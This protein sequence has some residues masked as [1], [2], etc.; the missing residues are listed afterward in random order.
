MRVD[1]TRVVNLLCLIL[2][3]EMIFSLPFHITRYFR[4]SF[5]E[6]FSLSN[7]ALGDIFALYGII[8]MLSYFPGG[9]LADKF[10]V[11]R[12]LTFSLLATAAGGLYLATIPGVNGL[13][14]LFAYWGMT[15][16]LLFWAALLRATREWG[17][18][19]RQGMAFGLLDG[20]R[21]LTAAIAAT[22]AVA[23]FSF[24][25]EG[26]TEVLSAVERR[27]GMQ[28]VFYFYSAVTGLVALL[29]W[30]F[31]RERRES[32]SL[33]APVVQRIHGVASNASVWLQAAIV[34]TAYC[35][36]KG[37][38]NY[39][40]YLVDV[41]Q[42]DEVRAAELMA[43][44]AYLRPVGAI[45][46]GLIADRFRPSRVIVCLFA[47]LVIIY[48]LLA[49]LQ[50]AGI[51]YDILMFNL[52]V[53]FLA[54]FALRGVYFA[55]LEEGRVASEQTGTAIGLVSVIGFTPDIFFY[56][57]GGRLLDRNPG[58]VGHQHYFWMLAAIACI[59]LFASLLLMRVVK[60]EK[61]TV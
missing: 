21:G 27:A 44:S 52:W 51:R 49:N 18:A 11:R 45:A 24:F 22:A 32:Q 6:T 4:P 43:M 2:A 58:I 30:M 33:P 31:V 20:G 9:L 59:G 8:A 36:Y 55:L 38:D 48:T 1:R 19:T 5:L 25:A 17:G 28:A 14:I 42:L 40:V 54:V 35:A 16:I 7:A 37:L 15:T 23:L 12:L 13:R 39:G 57:I 56:A 60:A 47:S 46:A 10:S 41:M 29:C 53:S 61:P 3:G 26:Q 34:L 50:P